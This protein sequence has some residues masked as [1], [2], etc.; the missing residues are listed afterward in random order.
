MTLQSLLSALHGCTQREVGKLQIPYFLTQQHIMGSK[1]TCA[2][3]RSIQQH[4]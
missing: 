1:Q 3:R 4:L 2:A